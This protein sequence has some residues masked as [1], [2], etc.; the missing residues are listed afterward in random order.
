VTRCLAAWTQL[1]GFVSFELFG[2]LVGVVD[3]EAAFDR[4]A[5][6]VGAFV[7]FD[8]GSRAPEHRPPPRA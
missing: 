6:D 1:F 3:G 4:V 2:H 7:G 8:E 5:A